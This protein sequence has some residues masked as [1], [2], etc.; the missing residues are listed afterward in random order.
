MEGFKLGIL[1][2]YVMEFGYNFTKDEELNVLLLKMSCD[3][4]VLWCGGV[5]LLVCHF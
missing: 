1:W 5:V 3:V 2:N 4:A